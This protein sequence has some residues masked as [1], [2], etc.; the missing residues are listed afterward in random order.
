MQASDVLGIDQ[1]TPI[2]EKKKKKKKTLGDVQCEK[3]FS[4]APSEEPGTL[5]SKDWPQWYSGS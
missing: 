5:N 3:S 1:D 2:I 4:V